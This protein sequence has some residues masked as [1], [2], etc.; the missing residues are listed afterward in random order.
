MHEKGK[1]NPQFGRKF[2]KC[3]APFAPHLA[4]EIWSIYGYNNS[5]AYEPFPEVMEEYLKENTFEY[6]VSFNGKVRFKLELAVDLSA[7]EIEEAVLQH[8]F[9]QKW[10]EGK[11]VKKVIVVTGKIVNI[12]IG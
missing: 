4:E 11:Q 5:L 1:C 6:P 12:V 8:E 3:L 2:I 9:T 10:T 7:K